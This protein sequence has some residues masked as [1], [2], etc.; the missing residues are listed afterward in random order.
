MEAF[1][2]EKYILALSVEA[3][4][5]IQP[6]E[7]APILLAERTCTLGRY[8]GRAYHFD[9]RLNRVPNSTSDCL[10][11]MA[12]VLSAKFI[13]ELQG[14]L[15]S[16]SF[17]DA[18]FGRC[19][20]WTMLSL[21]DAVLRKSTDDYL[22]KFDEFDRLC[23]SP[24]SSAFWSRKTVGSWLNSI[25]YSTIMALQ[26]KIE[27]DLET[28]GIHV[29]GIRYVSSAEYQRRHRKISTLPNPF[30]QITLEGPTL[31]QAWMDMEDHGGIKTIGTNKD[32]DWTPASTSGSSVFHGTT[33]KR[34]PYDQKEG[35]LS[36]PT[37]F[38]RSVE[39]TDMMIYHPQFRTSFVAFHSFLWG[40]F[41]GIIDDPLGYGAMALLQDTW[42]IG[43]HSY[44]GVLL[45]EFAL[46]Q[47]CSLEDL[48]QY[49]VDN[50][51]GAAD[52]WAEQALKDGTFGFLGDEDAWAKMEI[53]H[54]KQPP[55]YPDVIHTPEVEFTKESLE[56]WDHPKHMMWQS[57]WLTVKA[58]SYINSNT[59]NTF[60]LSTKQT[61]T[62]KVEKP[63][64]E[65]KNV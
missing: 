40:V 7:L 3:K 34:F 6:D 44:S 61:Q 21:D 62:K 27:N 16:S 51:A 2:K 65:D 58:M 25:V 60:S 33:I 43:R 39:K 50:T 5:Y 59:S 46:T 30:T 9:H 36:T 14:K 42:A 47:G 8:F 55:K 45:A 1:I 26:L 10:K 4:R 12:H 64:L 23:G 29:I 37:E 35:L 38:M 56:G 54:K 41:H 57:A 24:V 53:L 49:C 48:T 15:S 32:T 52:E 28:Q 63:T 31:R 20:L 11:D 17:N 22:E 19:C 13:K 18:V